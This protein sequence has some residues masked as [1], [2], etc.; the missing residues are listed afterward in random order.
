MELSETA[1]ALLTGNSAIRKSFEEGA[2]MAK[3]IGAE[4]V[5]D[6]SLGNPCARAPSKVKESIIRLVNECDGQY[7]H[8]YMKNAGYDEV[9]EAVAES[10]NRRYGMKYD[11]KNIVM[12]SGAAGGLNCIFRAFLNPGEEVV[13]FAPFFGEYKNY[14]A[15][16]GGRLVVVPPDTNTF[17]PN[18]DL[19]DSYIS[20]KTKIILLNNP[21]NPTG[22]IYSSEIFKNLQ[23][24]I[25][26]AQKRIGHEICVVSDE[27]YRELAYDGN[28][29][30]Y[31]PL[32]IKNC[33]VVYSFSKSLSLP[34][35]R[36]G[37]IAVPPETPLEVISALIAV[38]RVGYV[39]AP[40]LFQ[41]VVKDCLE[42]K[43]DLE[44]YDVNRRC[45]YEGLTRL[46]F[47]C[48]KPQGAFYLF[49]KSP[50][51]DEADFVA[52]GKKHNILMIPG[53]AFGCSGYVRLA[54]CIPQDKVKR[55]LD[56]FAELAKKYF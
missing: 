51:S 50:V 37:Y 41:L 46:G 20:E 9:R 29:V 35:E 1:K 52:E 10:L 24:K 49:L 44:F 18:L 26:E 31:V 23:G 53:S 34:G 2:E 28:T 30:P 19:L 4:N 12:T 39:N 48:L 15:S 27:P 55:S 13:C 25:N 43:A 40:S 36:I 22:V 14:V 32:Y 5:F 47:T 33:I 17:Q 42:E 7:L 56:A 6:F 38:M 11:A 45:L 21:N 16:A 3:K 54:Y 8:G